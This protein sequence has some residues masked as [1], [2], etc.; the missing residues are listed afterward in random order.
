MNSEGLDKIFQEGLSERKVDFNMDAWHK[1]EK[2]LPPEQPTKKVGWV[3][4]ALSV[5]GVAA[6]VVGGY[7]AFNQNA[8]NEPSSV[9]QQI[10]APVSQT[11]NATESN[12]AN[13]T[14]A[15]KVLGTEADVNPS[16]NSQHEAIV[17]NVDEV[18]P[19]SATTTFVSNSGTENTNVVLSQP[20][21]DE[22]AAS[23]AVK[24]IGFVKN[25][26][27]KI[28]GIGELSES[29]LA[30][31][32]QDDN[33]I[34]ADMGGKKRPKAQQNELGFIG[35]ANFNASIG[36]GSTA[37]KPS[38]FLGLSYTR[39]IK[40]G[41]S[42]KANL[43]YSHRNNMN[44][45]K[46]QSVKTYGFGSNIE[47]TTLHTNSLYYIDMP[48]MLNYGIGNGN[49]MIGAQA[50]YLVNGYHTLKTTNESIS[51]EIKETEENKFGYME[52]YNRFDVGLV[53]GYEHSI[54]PRWNLGARFNYGLLDV[55]KN[56]YF[57]NTQ[58]D[59]NKQFRLYVTYSPFKF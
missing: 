40:G 27:T 5:A 18:T 31:K 7:F 42:V 16:A 33:I 20:S 53:V 21:A 23:K 41:L 3:R 29:L 39:Y 48:I 19:S 43:L 38:E 11:E 52:G 22:N 26:F 46:I 57:Q 32:M 13:T 56:A 24:P 37:F 44:T 58:M 55:T 28:T 45:S 12:K 36:E 17:T 54:A 8:S 25:A 47:T 9:N 49:V 14:L 51:G 4:Y 1:M 59:R 35:G 30:A 2:M 34:V 10:V 50:S 6:A 15:P